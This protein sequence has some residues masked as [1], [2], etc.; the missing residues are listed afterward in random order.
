MSAVSAEPPTSGALD[1][2]V[3]PLT[4]GRDSG[5]G[6]TFAEASEPRTGSD[7]AG[8][9][10]SDVVFGA[11]VS[12][13][14]SG[15]DASA[16]D[17]VGAAACSGGGGS[18]EVVSPD[19]AVAAE[20]SSSGSSTGG[21][22]LALTASGGRTSST[23]M[24]GGGAASALSGSGCQSRNTSTTA[25][26]IIEATPVQTIHRSRLGGWGSVGSGGVTSLMDQPL[27]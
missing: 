4:L 3:N 7:A 8:A 5:I 9:A 17:G 6:A 27:P 15:A 23:S 10:A 2:A 12:D 13:G 24:A 1:G 25:C 18:A 26:S 20:A 19:G 11:A 22:S 16:A 14:I 21:G